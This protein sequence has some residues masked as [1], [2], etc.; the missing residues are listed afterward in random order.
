MRFVRMLEDADPL[1][2]WDTWSSIGDA[3]GKVGGW[4]PFR[5]AET[6]YGRIETAR[7]WEANSNERQAPTSVASLEKAARDDGFRVFRSAEK[8]VL[9]YRQTLADAAVAYALER[10]DQVYAFEA[11]P[12]PPEQ[13]PF[14]LAAMDARRSP[15][16]MLTRSLA[17]RVKWLTGKEA[18]WL[19][20]HV[21]SREINVSAIHN[22]DG[23]GLWQQ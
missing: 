5:L 7:K 8:A 9:R 15:L 21:Q 1:V 22:V 3:D 18:R 4:P 23:A 16:V 20:R 14:S 2:L 10:A 17:D 6:W 12:L 19:M 11:S 13:G